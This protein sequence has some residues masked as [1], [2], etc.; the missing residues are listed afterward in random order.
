VNWLTDR[1]LAHL[2]DPAGHN[3]I[4]HAGHDSL[5]REMNCLLSRS[6]L[7]IHCGAG[8]VLGPSRYEPA[9]AGDIA[10]LATYRVHV[11]EDDVV[12]G[13]GVDPGAIQ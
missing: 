2:L 4:V 1:D 9:G 7:A 12:N 3:Q 5:S 11:A 6:A 13:S 10:G 8:H